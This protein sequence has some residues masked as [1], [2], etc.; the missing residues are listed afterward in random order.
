MKEEGRGRT[1]MEQSLHYTQI[2]EMAYRTQ[3]L[4]MLVRSR[5]HRCCR[6]AFYIVN[7]ANPSDVITLLSTHAKKDA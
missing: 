4:A 7:G 3:K 1:S 5:C 2:T 6:V